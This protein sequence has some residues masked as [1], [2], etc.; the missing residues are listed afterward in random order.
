MAV[1]N[2]SVVDVVSVDH[3]K[4]CVV[5]DIADHLDWSEEQQHLLTLE[6]KINAYLEFIQSGQLCEVYPDAEGQAPIIHVA[7]YH[8]PTK[9]AIAFFNE[10]GRI[11][12]TDDIRLT[13]KHSH[14]NSP[15]HAV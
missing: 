9:A 11:L 15:P 7:C 3:L 13:Y 6:K 12:A 2:P 4:K 14:F 8:E 5:L 1:D 10:V